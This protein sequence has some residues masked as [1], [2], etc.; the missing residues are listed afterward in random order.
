MRVIFAGTPEF[1]RLAYEAIAKAGHEVPLVLTQPDRPSGRGLKLTPSPVKQ[2]ALAQGAQV[3]QPQSLRLDGKYPDE[4]RQAQQVLQALAPDVMVVAAYGLILPQWV[5]DL[6]KYGCLNIHASLLPRWRGAAPIQRAIEAGDAQTGVAIMQMD[7]GLDTGDVLLEKRIDITDQT[8][9]V[10]H[11]QLAA[12]GAEC[13]TAVLG[14]LGTG[15]LKAVPQPEEGVTYAAKLEKSEAPI[16]IKQ[17]APTIAR[18]IRAFNP[19]PGA[20]LQL[21]GLK[22]PVKVW[23][24]VALNENTSAEPGTVLRATADG[25]DIATG[26]GV[27]RLLELQKAGGK[28]QPVAVFVTGW[29]P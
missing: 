2:E 16:D 18:R 27:L 5:L 6:P 3:L 9:A 17:D 15:E 1:A 13:I 12:M 7:A 26:Q 28:R 25:V 21:P 29:K 10:L 20:T 19:V 14:K 11:D 8:A 24:A 22:D 23:Q 4:A